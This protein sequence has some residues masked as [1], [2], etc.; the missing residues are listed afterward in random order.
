MKIIAKKVKHRKLNAKN[1]VAPSQLEILYAVRTLGEERKLGQY[2]LIENGQARYF[3]NFKELRYYSDI[4][5]YAQHKH[6]IL[7]K[8][9]ADEPQAGLC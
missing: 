7:S 2:K 9:E 1:G 5:L 3:K 4:V 6:I 8:G